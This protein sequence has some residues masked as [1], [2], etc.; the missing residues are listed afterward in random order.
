VAKLS[1]QI[2]R[3]RK[4]EQAEKASLSRQA[5]KAYRLRERRKSKGATAFQPPRFPADSPLGLQQ[6]DSTADIE[7][8]Q[9]QEETQ[10]PQDWESSIKEE[11]RSGKGSQIKGSQFREGPQLSGSG[12]TSEESQKPSQI[13]S[14]REDPQLSGSGRISAGI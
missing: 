6:D 2:S 13:E 1:E 3:L 4:V 14:N 8:K 7:E 11:D 9:A 12:R 5:R 10:S